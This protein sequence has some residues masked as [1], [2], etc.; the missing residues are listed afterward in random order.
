LKIDITKE[1]IASAA[2][3]DYFSSAPNSVVHSW[4]PPDSK[5]YFT[6]LLYIPQGGKRYHVDLIVQI[7]RILYLIEVKDCLGNSY[8]DVAKLQQIT[9]SFST[10]EL[11]QR[12]QQQGEIFSVV[13]CKTCIAIAAKDSD[14]AF[15]AANS[16]IPVL[17]ADEETVYGAND[18]GG[19]L[20]THLVGTL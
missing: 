4:H 19:D 12:F 17:L 8:D 18:L 16:D 1:S 9:H 6:R 11:V 5:A 2:L 3:Y 14:G 15:L 10:Q 20:L 7:G 13:P